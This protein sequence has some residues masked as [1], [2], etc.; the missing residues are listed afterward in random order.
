MKIIYRCGITWCKCRQ[1]LPILTSKHLELTRKGRVYDACVWS[2]MLHGIETWAT[3]K[4]DLEQL[5][6]CDRAMMRWIRRF[7]LRDNSPTEQL[8]AKLGV[9]VLSSV[10]QANRLRWFGHAEHTTSWINKVRDLS[11]PGDKAKVLRG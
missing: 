1:V 4:T 5:H 10:L 8:C 11:V 9:V 2:A 7:S 6:R 3:R